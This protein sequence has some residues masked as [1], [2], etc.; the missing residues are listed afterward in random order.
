MSKTAII[1]GESL[2]K[3]EM[4]KLKQFEKDPLMSQLLNKLIESA[5]VD[6]VKESKEKKI[7]PCAVEVQRKNALEILEKDNEKEMFVYAQGDSK[8]KIYTQ[9]TRPIYE[10]D[11]EKEKFCWKHSQVNAQHPENIILFEK[12]KESDT[13]RSLGMDDTVFTTSP[14]S[15]T[16]KDTLNFICSY[17]IKKAFAEALGED[18]P[19]QPTDTTEDEKEVKVVDDQDEEVEE[20]VEGASEEA[21]DEEENAEEDE[22]DC[23]EITTNDGRQLY[24]NSQ[25]NQIYSPEGDESGK[26]LGILTPVAELTTLQLNGVYQIVANPI[27]YNSVNYLRCALSDKLYQSADSEMKLVG[28]VT[29]QKNGEYKVH[30]AQ[31][32]KAT[33]AKKEVPKKEATSS[34]KESTPAKKSESSSTKKE[35]TP[36][37][38]SSSAST[39]K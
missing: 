29:M 35:T 28:K 31:E 16:A 36:A 24:W 5:K 15:K 7:C 14:A 17:E 8:E 9:C 13:S 25:T 22:I 26:E 10:K 12:I 39:K 30:L 11:N 32:K 19:E 3:N 21:G 38:K 1:G 23:Q 27:E 2:S 20:T 34:K 18:V 33:P 6:A 37:K 4:E